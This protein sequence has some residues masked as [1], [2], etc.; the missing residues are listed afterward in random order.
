MRMSCTHKRSLSFHG[1]T[2]NNNNNNEKMN[3][4]RGIHNHIFRRFNKRV[5]VI[6]ISRCWWYCYY[7]DVN[8]SLKWSNLMR[9]METGWFFVSLW[10]RLGFTIFV[11]KEMTW[12]DRWAAQYDFMNGRWIHGKSIYFYTI[13]RKLTVV[14]N[15]HRWPTN[16]L[17][18]SLRWKNNYCYYYYWRQYHGKLWLWLHSHSCSSSSKWMGHRGCLLSTPFHFSTIFFPH[19]IIMATLGTERWTGKQA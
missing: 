5:P 9:T 2:Y 4:K 3:E 8:S 7:C 15:K 10:W 13:K 16:L 14:N 1:H 6:D 19:C 17:G 11:H 12:L 18:C